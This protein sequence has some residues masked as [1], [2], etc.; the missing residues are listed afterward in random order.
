MKAKVGDPVIYFTTEEDQKR[1][2]ENPHNTPRQQLPGT[3]TAIVGEGEDERANLSVQHDGY[4][5]TY[6]PGVKEGS[7]AGQF[8]MLNAPIPSSDKVI[9]ENPEQPVAHVD[10]GKVVEGEVSQDTTETVSPV[11]APTEPPVEDQTKVEA[12]DNPGV[13]TEG[14]IDAKTQEKTEVKAEPKT[15]QKAEKP[16]VVT[17]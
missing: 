15:A 8:K 5:T 16:K 1:M 11:A 4:G 12:K 7:E 14:K 6:A 9:V 3:V 2:G 17:K 10:N 13:K